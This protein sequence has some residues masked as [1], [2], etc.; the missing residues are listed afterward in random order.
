MLLLTLDDD[1]AIGRLI[2][3]IA[4]TAGYQT[5]A[6]TSSAEF[7]ALYR[8]EL[9]DLILLDL[10]IGDTD[11][12]EELRFLSNKAYPNALILASGYDRRVLA[13]AE[14]LAQELGLKVIATLPKPFHPP[15]LKHFLEQV[16]DGIEVSAADELLEAIAKNQ[17]LLE[18]QPI[19]TRRE[20]AVRSFEALIRWDHPKSGRLAPIQF[21]PTAEGQPRVMHAMT[22]WVI[23]TAIKQYI[24]LR[25]NGLTT[26]IAVNISGS[27]LHD[28]DFPDRLHRRLREARLPPRHFCL[29]ITDGAVSRDAV[30][31]MEI[32]SRLRLKGVDLAIDDFG[33]GHWSLARFRQL[34]FSII[35]IADSFVREMG[36]SAEA[37]KTVEACLELAQDWN[38]ETIA[39]GVETEA[40]AAQLVTLGVNAM[41]GHL[42]APALPAD[43]LVAW[44]R[45]WRE[46]SGPAPARGA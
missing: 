32:L 11:G 41:Q 33:T 18:Y 17:L 1:A 19:V 46:R 16:K 6:A 12:V 9:P 4:A 25:D 37:L 38:I 40:E 35:K 2:N 20:G 26:P 39:E 36:H 42:I 27:S 7:R 45:Q 15:A 10:H 8:K 21:I 28:T 5:A 30:R 22:E 43:Q 14:A 31:P 24:R 34:P 29:E 13:T 23:D 44:L 3:R